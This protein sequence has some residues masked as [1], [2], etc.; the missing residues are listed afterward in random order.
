MPLRGCKTH[1]DKCPKPVLFPENVEAVDLFF[2]CF[3]Q[4]VVDNFGIPQI[5][6]SEVDTAAK[7]LGVEVDPE[8]FSKFRV[9]ERELKRIRA[10]KNGKE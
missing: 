5:A 7:W 2:A 10:A 1:C 6:Y 3:T 9:M 4:F 8:L